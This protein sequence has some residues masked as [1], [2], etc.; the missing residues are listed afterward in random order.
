MLFSC[1]D[2]FE[3]LR[4]QI[5]NKK[6]S[7]DTENTSLMYPVI[8][9]TKA[10]RSHNYDQGRRNGLGMGGGVGWQNEFL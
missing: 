2:L 3:W 4:L 6:G 8:F 9:A 1:K 10:F 5:T 7:Q